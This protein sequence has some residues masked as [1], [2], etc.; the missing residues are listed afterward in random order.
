MLLVLLHHVGVALAHP[1]P[2][3][4]DV[5]DA[6]APL[7]LGG[8]GGHA[9]DR[10]AERPQLWP[11]RTGVLTDW[12][13]SHKPSLHSVRIIGQ[14]FCYDNFR[15]CKVLKFLCNFLQLFVDFG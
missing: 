7:A 6:G 9:A 1:A 11:H 2:H 14:V 13:I 5:A 15:K 3:G 4:F 8:G 12:A 10:A